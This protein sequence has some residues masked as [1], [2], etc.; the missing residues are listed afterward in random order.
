MFRNSFFFIAFALF[1]LFLLCQADFQHHNQRF[2][3]GSGHIKRFIY[4]GP[5][6]ND[7]NWGKDNN[8]YYKR[9]FI[10][11]N[12]N[13]WGKQN[14]RYYNGGQGSGKQYWGRNQRYNQVNNKFNKR[15]Q[16]Y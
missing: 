2:G 11:R 10:G 7:N 13:N 12:N 9:R 6:Q 4:N 8:R 14:N 5:N 15:Y 16:G 3:Q 1:S